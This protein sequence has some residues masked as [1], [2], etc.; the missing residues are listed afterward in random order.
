MSA[1]RESWRERAAGLAWLAGWRLTRLLPEQRAVALFERFADRSYRVNERRRATVRA[2]LEPVVPAADLDRVVRE[3]FRSY[4]R[5][6]AETFRMQDLS[7]EEL[8]RRFSVD[9]VENIQ[10]AYD[11]GTGAVLATLHIGNWD[12]GGRWVSERWPLTAVAE[13]LR[14][15]MLFERFVAHRRSLGM[16]I[17]PL[18]RGG[19]ATKQCLERLDAGELVALVADRDLSGTGIEVRMF[20]RRTKMP[21]GPAVL[22]LRTGAHLLPACIYMEPGGRWRAVVMERIDSGPAPDE[23]T[24]VAALTQRLASAFEVLIERHPEQWHAFQRS[25]LPDGGEGGGTAP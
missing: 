15:R 2:N 9:G 17:V 4:G 20:G 7:R 23:A 21:P 5:Y 16:T 19:D 10:K 25:W 18:V 1:R 24:A 8:A 22:S 13:V 14:P 6:W 11:G 3:A 12:A